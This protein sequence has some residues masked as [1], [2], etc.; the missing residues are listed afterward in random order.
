MIQAMTVKKSAHKQNTAV[1]I[2]VSTAANVAAPDAY[3]LLEYEV[4]DVVC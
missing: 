2:Y 3:E 4:A 1:H